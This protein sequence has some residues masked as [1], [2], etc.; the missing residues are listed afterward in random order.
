MQLSKDI[1]I[2]MCNTILVFILDLIRL[3]IILELIEKLQLKP[4]YNFHQIYWLILMFIL[5]LQQ[6]LVLRF[7]SLFS[8][9]NNQF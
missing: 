2:K 1:A 3:G 6:F 5:D 9:S 7:Y 8:R 4:N